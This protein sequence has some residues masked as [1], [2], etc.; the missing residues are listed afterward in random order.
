MIYQNISWCSHVVSYTIMRQVV[1]GWPRAAISQ[2]PTP[3]P[4]CQDI[5]SSE[6]IRADLRMLP[7]STWYYTV[8][9]YA[10][11]HAIPDYTMLYHTM[12]CYTLLCNTKLYTIEY[13]T[14]IHY[15]MHEN[16]ELRWRSAARNPR[17]PPRGACCRRLPGCGLTVP[18]GYLEIPFT[19][20][21]LKSLNPSPKKH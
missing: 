10:S 17:F 7:Y 19:F 14:K 18:E 13:N 8:P 6:R 5:C 21:F 1:V 20:W 4:R 12:Q 11:L 9:Y 2:L 3:W 16:S 15:A